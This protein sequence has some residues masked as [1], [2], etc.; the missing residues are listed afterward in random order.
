M[1][2]RNV[3][4]GKTIEVPEKLGRHLI[5]TREFVADGESE[6]VEPEPPKKQ[7]KRYKRRDLRA[8]K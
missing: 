6:P 7:A 1:K 5:T 3:E 2:I 8:E 4:N